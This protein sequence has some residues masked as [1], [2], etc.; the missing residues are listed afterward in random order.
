[1]ISLLSLEA[2]IDAEGASCILPR[3]LCILSSG[4]IDGLVQLFCGAA[5]DIADVEEVDA[6]PRFCCEAGV[7]NA[8]GSSVPIPEDS[9]VA[10]LPFILPLSLPLPTP[11]L[12]VVLIGMY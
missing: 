4:E 1:M 12:I 5:S 10:I 2:W 6:S 7:A 11:P 3:V 9:C 8:V